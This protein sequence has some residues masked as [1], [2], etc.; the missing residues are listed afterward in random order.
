MTPVQSMGLEGPLVIYLY[1]LTIVALVSSTTSALSCF[2]Y[3]T[4]NGLHM[5]RLLDNKETCSRMCTW[6]CL[7][8]CKLLDNKETCSRTCTWTYV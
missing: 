6:T 7:Y 4:Y 2:E 1:S 8:M 5:C 3:F